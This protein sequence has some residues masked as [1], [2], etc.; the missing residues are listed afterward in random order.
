MGSET[1]TLEMDSA[2]LARLDALAA[3][4]NSSRERLAEQALDAG[5]VISHEAL[6]A[7][8]RARLDGVTTASSGTPMVTAGASDSIQ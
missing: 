7:E 6:M 2:T 5:D 4:L 1:L 3:A 8:L